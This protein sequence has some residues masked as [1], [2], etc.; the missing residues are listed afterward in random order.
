VTHLVTLQLEVDVNADWT[1]AD[2]LADPF[3]HL[4]GA[5]LVGVRRNTRNYSL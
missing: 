1:T 2:A 3:G 5:V 4:H